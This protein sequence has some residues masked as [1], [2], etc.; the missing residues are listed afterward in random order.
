MN[1]SGILIMFELHLLIVISVESPKWGASSSDPGRNS[2]LSV[3]KGEWKDYQARCVFTHTLW[4]HLHRTLF[5]HI[6]M[7][8]S[9]C[10]SMPWSSLTWKMKITSQSSSS[11]TVVETGRQ[12]RGCPDA[13]DDRL[14]EWQGEK[15]I[16]HEKTKN[17]QVSRSSVKLAGANC[18]TADVVHQGNKASLGFHCNTKKSYLILSFFMSRW[19]NYNF[20]TV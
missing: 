8:T 16:L 14:R 7:L 18:T 3:W 15:Y 20:C 17:S 12:H 9:Y 5:C 10:W 4:T 1:I 2:D 13:E 19:P 6:D 11:F